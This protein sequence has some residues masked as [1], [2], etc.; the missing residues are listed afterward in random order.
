MDREHAEELVGAAGTGP[1]DLRDE[2]AMIE[3]L[4]AGDKS[5]CTQCV[6]LHA[7][8]VYRLALR[9]LGDAAEAE[10]VTQEVFLNAFRSIER[11][12]WRSGLQTWLYR[13][14]HNQVLMRK[15]KR[16]PL[17]VTLDG[18]GDRAH[19]GTAALEDPPVVPQQ[20]FDWCCLPDA[21][22]ATAEAR[23]E[24]EAAIA[25]MPPNLRE[26]FVLRELEGLSG[27]ET[28]AALGI[29]LANVKVRLHRARLWLRERLAD[30]FTELAQEH[31]AGGKE[32][33]HGA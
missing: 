32:A 7:P 3:R 9:M 24:L 12:E 8:G 29:T 28:A 19:A 27:E 25:A 33:Q 21:D 15:R 26:V 11:F 17:F 10:D 1:G 5:A 2:Q 14:T 13:I 22:F 20:L 4:R 18:T 30:Y 16:E 31:A 23:G 6:E